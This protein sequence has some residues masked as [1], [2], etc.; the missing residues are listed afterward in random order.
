MTPQGPTTIVLIPSVAIQREAKTLIVRRAAAKAQ[1]GNS[2]G[3]GQFS[4]DVS[5]AGFGLSVVNRE[6]KELLYMSCSR[7]R[8]SQKPVKMLRVHSSRLNN[9][10]PSNNNMRAPK[11]IFR[12]ENQERET[13]VVE[14]AGGFINFKHE[15]ASFKGKSPIYRRFAPRVT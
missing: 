2:E 13:A 8:L 3:V 10:P 11:L 6:P 9:L 4:L 14:N 1:G 12:L 5:F 7:V 15:T